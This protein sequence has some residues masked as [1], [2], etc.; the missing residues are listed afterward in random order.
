MLRTLISPPIII[1]HVWPL[2]VLTYPILLDDQSLVN[3]FQTFL[4]AIDKCCEVT[5]SGN[6]QY[7]VII[8]SD[9]VAVTFLCFFCIYFSDVLVLLPSILV[10]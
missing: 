10:F 2:Q 5:L 1:C 4:E 6:H 9:F 7:L 3:E 8:F